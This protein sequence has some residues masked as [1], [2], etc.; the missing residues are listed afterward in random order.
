[1]KKIF[2]ML[3]FSTSIFRHYTIKHFKNHKLSL[4]FNREYHNMI[5][6]LFS[7]ILRK[8]LF[9]FKVKGGIVN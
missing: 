3:K 6:L 8:K 2:G 7:K 9:D 4:R 5:Y 1:M